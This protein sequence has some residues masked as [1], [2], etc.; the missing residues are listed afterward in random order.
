MNA[1]ETR[2]DPVSQDQGL[3]DLGHPVDCGNPDNAAMVPDLRWQYM[4]AQEQWD[5][6]TAKDR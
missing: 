6:F 3:S 1:R 2:K 5:L 4:T